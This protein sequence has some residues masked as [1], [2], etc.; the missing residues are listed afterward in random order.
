MIEKVVNIL[1]FGNVCLA[2]SRSV[3]VEDESAESPERERNSMYVFAGLVETWGE[4]IVA[5]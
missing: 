2:K 3:F 4:K 5:Y 1:G